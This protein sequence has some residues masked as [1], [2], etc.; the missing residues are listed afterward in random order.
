MS[1]C[2]PNLVHSFLTVCKIIT[3]KVDKKVFSPVPKWDSRVLKAQ[4]TT[5]SSR[6][7]L[8]DILFLSLSELGI[9]LQNLIPIGGV[10]H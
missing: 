10:E 8:W 7:G 9:C 1:T 2:L 4:K 3:F 6:D 5:F